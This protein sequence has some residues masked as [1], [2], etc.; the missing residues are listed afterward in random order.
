MLKDQ[1]KSRT[2]KEKHD[3]N[4][5]LS[6]QPWGEDGDK[7]KYY[8]IEGQDDTSFRVYRE[9]DL[10][11]RKEPRKDNTT[12][13]S[14]AGSIDELRVLA[15]KLADDDGTRKAKA[16]SERILNAIPRFEATEEVRG[17][18]P[19]LRS[20]SV[21]YRIPL[22][23][24]NL[25]GRARVLI[26]VVPRPIASHTCKAGY[27]DELFLTRLQ[28]RK[29]R[30]YRLNRKAA[31]T[32]PDPGFYSYETRTRGK[33]M[34]YTFSD[35]EEDDEGSDAL[36]VRR[37][38][39]HGRDAPAVASGPTVTASG[40]QVR[41][42]ATGLYGETLLSGQATAEAASPATGD[43]ERSDA[44]GDQA[45]TNGRATRAAKEF[46]NSGGRGRKHIE[47]YNSVDEMDDEDDATSSGGEWDG[48]DEDEKADQMDVDED[49]EEE[50]E[51]EDGEP[52]TLVVRLRYGK[53]STKPT[54]PPT[55]IKSPELPPSGSGVH[56][57]LPAG[58]SAPPTAP[59]ESTVPPPQETS[60]I[61]P[62]GSII[63]QERPVV[64]AP[65]ESTPPG[66][67]HTQ[68]KAWPAF[69]PTPPY[70][71]PADSLP[72]SPF[73]DTHTAVPVTANTQ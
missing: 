47:T 58:P 57:S 33:R 37:S 63:H 59:V 55:A 12:W 13:Y 53:G 41:S 17:A 16:L 65:Q 43:Y 50:S 35:E 32:R 45:S 25:R 40:R 64:S 14:S 7:R 18:F 10:T 21:P 66:N 68:P 11:A 52:K 5:P 72:K 44:S 73:P 48:E 71:P 61:V 8:L 54:V 30:E 24:G 51:S 34:K 23:T 42:R 28:K 22:S 27:Y 60:N 9:S 31:F 46:S 26:Q 36:S 15:Q 3:V 56:S 19:I 69:A 62:N 38:G 29:R 1:Y 67:A 6:V 4:I 20:S 39:R 2:S 70:N 49:E